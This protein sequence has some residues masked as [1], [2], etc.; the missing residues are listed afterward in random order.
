L[1]TLADR[2]NVAISLDPGRSRSAMRSLR[3]RSERDPYLQ[4]GV[5]MALLTRPAFLTSEERAGLERDVSGV[6]N[7]LFEL[8][9]RLFDGDIG[10]L[11]AGSGLDADQCAAV[12]A[13]WRD[14]DVVLSRADLLRDEEGFKAIEV[15]VHS[16]LGGIDNGPMHRA[17]TSLP[18]FR[19]FIA[20]EGLDYVDPM[21]GVAAALRGA[22]TRRGLGPRP[23]VAL[24]EWPTK[25]LTSAD[26]LDR[27]SRLLESRGFSAFGC[28]A[29]ELAVR[30]GRLVHDGRPIDILYRTFLLED[31]PQA[32][33]LLEPI[34]TAHRSGNLLLAMSF[35]AEIIGNKASLALLSDCVER[36]LFSPEEQALVRRTVPWTRLVRRGKTHWRGRRCDL[37]DLALRAQNRLVLKPA[38]GHSARGVM[39][40]WRVSQREW[41]AAL[42]QAMGGAWVLQ[43]RVRPVTEMMPRIEGEPDRVRFERVD[44]NWGVFIMGGRYGGTMLRAVPS[45]RGGVISSETDASIGC[46]FCSSA[47]A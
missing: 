2:L 7:L 34:L 12:E 17:F 31:V 3:E 45:T 6:V 24:V 39:L 9:G 32:P 46:C 37:Y 5:G 20:A 8:P 18:V 36:G 47:P 29:G 21:D 26:R 10:A 42:E 27:I 25:Y 40:G 28:H 44:M 30:D 38:G 4:H 41:R 16:S 14:R 23:T 43:E 15:N 1:S 11:C 35:A 33:A 22:A 19:E 13:T